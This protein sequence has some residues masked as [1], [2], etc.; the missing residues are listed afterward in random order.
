MQK[1]IFQILNGKI[2]MMEYWPAEKK[3]PA[4]VLLRS[5][6][7]DFGIDPSFVDREEIIDGEVT[8]QRGSVGG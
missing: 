1:D 2:E 7:R 8:G 3:V 5:L 6:A 4:K